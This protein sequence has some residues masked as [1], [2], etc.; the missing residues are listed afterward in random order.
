MGERSYKVKFSSSMSLK[1]FKL[2]L[3]AKR[4]LKWKVKAILFSTKLYYQIY[5]KVLYKPHHGNSHLEMG[6]WK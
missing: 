6:L 1:K 5:P 3:D 4:R 2:I